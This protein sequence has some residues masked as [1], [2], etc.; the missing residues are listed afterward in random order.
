VK[1]N[2][3]IHVSDLKNQIGERGPHP[4]LFCET[5][6]ATFTANEGDYFMRSPDYVFKHCNRNMVL[7]IQ[8]T[9]YERVEA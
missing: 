5:C 2:K 4:H 9:V 1:R 8:R 3:A 6:G 7:A